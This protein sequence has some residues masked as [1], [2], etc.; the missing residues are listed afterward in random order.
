MTTP[1]DPLAIYRIGKGQQFNSMKPPEESDGEEDPL[2][3]YRIKPTE[4]EAFSVK[5]IPRIQQGIA[6][7]SLEAGLGAPEET[8]RGV[9]TLLDMIVGGGTE[10]I[11]GK[12]HPK[13]REFL[14]DPLSSLGKH[15]ATIEEIERGSLSPGESSVF[16]KFPTS[17]EI[18]QDIT[19]PASKAIT[20]E[21]NYLEPKNEA[22]K[23]AQEFSQDILRLSLPGSGAQSWAQ[24]IGLSF[25]GNSAKEIAN[26][27]GYDPS[28]QELAKFGA[29]GVLSLAQLGNAP[30]FAREFFNDTKSLMPRGVRFNTQPLQNELAKIKNSQWYKGHPTPSTKAAREMISSIEKRIKTGTLSVQDGMTLRENINELANNLGAFKVSGTSYGP[31]VANL[32]EVRSALIKGMEQTVGKQYPS[33][34]KQYQDANTAFAITQRS[35]ALGNFI[36]HNYAKPL[37]SDAGKVLFGNALAKGA[38]GVAQLGIAGASIATG[39]KAITLANRIYQSPTLRRY[40]ADVVQQAARGNVAAMTSAL[41]K[42]DEAALKEQKHEKARKVLRNPSQK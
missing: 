30:R 29:L 14:K 16:E 8:K 12:K 37:L 10:Y 40:Y 35:G 21:E 26:Q 20:G 4:N 17:E 23:F 34:W 11:T 9:G 25:A 42:F 1:T 31:H 13:L 36:A 32:N 38:A 6:A 3:E 27:L 18:R 19:K 7:R 5:D 39:A 2:N 28:T 41:E 24:R 33:W 15:R 22:E